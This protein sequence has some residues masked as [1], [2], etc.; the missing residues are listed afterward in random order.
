MK[1]GFMLLAIAVLLS[2]LLYGNAWAVDDADIQVLQ[3]E[4]SSTKSKADKNTA[5][6]ENMKGG[7]PAEAAARKAADEEL[8]NLINN[9]QLTPGPQGEPGPEGPVG[10]AGPQ[11]EQGEQGETGPAGPQGLQGETGATGPQGLKGDTG[12]RGSQGSPGEAGPP[13]PEGPPGPPAGEPPFVVPARFYGNA[14]ISIY[15]T[16]KV[17]ELIGFGFGV[18]ALFDASGNFDGIQTEAVLQLPNGEVTSLMM[19]AAVGGGTV[20]VIIK[21]Y[22]NENVLEMELASVT[23][24]E[25]ATF[26]SED[27][28][29][30]TVIVHLVPQ[31]YTIHFG[32]KSI[33]NTDSVSCKLNNIGYWVY[34]MHDESRI[35]STGFN[36]GF[37]GIAPK[38]VVEDV[39]VFSLLTP[40]LQVLSENS[41][42]LLHNLLEQQHL[43]VQIDVIPQNC[44]GQGPI[45]E[46]LTLSNPKVIGFKLLPTNFGTHPYFLGIEVTYSQYT[47]VELVTC[48]ISGCSH[49]AACSSV[50]I[51]P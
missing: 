44:D 23:N 37:S 47:E 2:F 19:T 27:D 40:Q 8:L 18:R 35:L 11:G 7:L 46:T 51:N 39:S 49:E 29:T 21:D 24:V 17:L 16:D 6:I 36:F 50:I 4:V 26:P 25:L 14:E 48:D 13:G 43:N 41:L 22:Y 34:N 30:G 33:G 1:K 10:P 31:T 9:I 38:I 3:T 32:S 28:P 45:L 20:D 12:E 15:A 5:D 42:C